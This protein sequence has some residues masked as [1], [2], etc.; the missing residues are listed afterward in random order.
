MSAI[1]EWHF[2]IVD[3]IEAITDSQNPRRYWSDLKRQL[4]QDE[5]AEL[6]EEIVQLKMPSGDG[7]LHPTSRQHRPHHRDVSGS[8]LPRVGPRLQHP[9]Q[10]AAWLSPRP[11]GVGKHPPDSPCPRL[12]ERSHLIM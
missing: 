10:R 12:C 9:D 8:P 6:Y 7:K 11:G 4:A 2:S 5:G 1:D 3:V